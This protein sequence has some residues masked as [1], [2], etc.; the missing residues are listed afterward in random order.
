MNLPRPPVYRITVGQCLLLALSWWFVRL[1]GYPVV[2]DSV[3]Y[4]GLIAV[5]PQAWFAWRVFQ[6]RGARSATHIARAS[7]SGEVAKFVLT[8]SGFAAV[9]ALVRPISGGAVFAGYGE[10][11]V[12]QIV[13]SWWLL[14]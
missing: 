5:L 7:Y 13:G 14:K 10:M 9:F 12:I 6:Y 4:G 3:F 1:A 8:V 11:L 2:A